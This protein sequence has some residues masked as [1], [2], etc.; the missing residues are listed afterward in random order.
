MRRQFLPL[1]ILA[2]LFLTA[3]SFSRS[4]GWNAVGGGNNAKGGMRY[5]FPPDGL[6]V[7]AWGVRPNPVLAKAREIIFL[8]RA[9]P[10]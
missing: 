9:L 4:R 10:K 5:A 8:T 3:F 7:E 6:W 1:N 2:P